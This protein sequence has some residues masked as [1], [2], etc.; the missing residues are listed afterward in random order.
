M[1][2]MVWLTACCRLHTCY[3]VL[4]PLS[5]VLP[6]QAHPYLGPQ[7]YS[8]HLW[9]SFNQ[10]HLLLHSYMSI[11]SNVLELYLWHLLNLPSSVEPGVLKR[12]L[13]SVSLLSCCKNHTFHI[14]M[15]LQP[16]TPLKVLLPKYTSTHNT[17]FNVPFPAFSNLSLLNSGLGFHVQSSFPS[18]L[19]LPLCP[20]ASPCQHLLSPLTSIK[21]RTLPSSCTDQ[22]LLDQQS[23]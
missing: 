9:W 14:K 13:C 4:P 11:Y 12:S 10:K 3:Y 5:A 15:D 7:F 8:I 19:H 1:V 22:T 2:G 21:P 6:G 20:F 16:I 18:I 23:L 17:K